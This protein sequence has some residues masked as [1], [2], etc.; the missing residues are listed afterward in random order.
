V[1]GR[2]RPQTWV[3]DD[4]QKLESHVNSSLTT[5]IDYLI[6]RLINCISPTLRII[7]SKTPTN[8]RRRNE[9]ESF[10]TPYSS[11]SPAAKSAMQLHPPFLELSASVDPGVIVV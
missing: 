5:A 10:D 7:V 6:S 1:G 11:S 9:I 2:E 3:R 8:N 4:S